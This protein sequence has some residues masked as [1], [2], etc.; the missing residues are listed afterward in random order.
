MATL[1]GDLTASRR[2][3]PHWRTII[4][5]SLVALVVVALTIFSPQTGAPLA[6]DLAVALVALLWPTVGLYLLPGA[7]AFGSV[8]AVS[9]AG[10][11]AGPTD[12]LVAGLTLA[13][14]YSL[15]Q[16][17]YDARPSVM[18]ERVRE[19]WR[20]APE[21]V[22]IFGCVALYLLVGDRFRFPGAESCRDGEGDPEVDGGPDRRRRSILFLAR[23]H[24]NC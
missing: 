20:T 7:V 13:W 24:D 14:L 21:Q 22:L 1:T 6:L 4:L 2:P 5:A 19:A 12:A 9:A 17:R 16:Q 10:V 11:R 3:Q 8:V 23:I 18:V 15:R